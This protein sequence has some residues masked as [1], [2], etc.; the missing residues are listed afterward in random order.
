MTVSGC[1]MERNG[2]QI[3]ID[4]LTTKNLN[5]HNFNKYRIIKLHNILVRPEFP[6]AVDPANQEIQRRVVDFA[7][8]YCTNYFTHIYDCRR[9]HAS[10]PAP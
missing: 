6:D 1:G 9:W 4:W 3:Q 2:F 5:N 8:H 10:H 7:C